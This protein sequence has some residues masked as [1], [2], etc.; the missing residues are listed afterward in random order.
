MTLELFK[1]PVHVFRVEFE[2]TADSTHPSL[3]HSVETWLNDV[4]DFEVDEWAV[5]VEVDFDDVRDEQHGKLYFFGL[6]VLLEL[7]CD[8]FCLLNVVI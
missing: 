8:V 1:Y 5:V 7:R 3:V 6:V 2:I 4:S